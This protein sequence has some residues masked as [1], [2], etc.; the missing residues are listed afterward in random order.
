MGYG[1][2]NNV[3]IR[4][5][6]KKG[7]GPFIWILNNDTVVDK[8][9]L[10][11]LISCVKEDKSIGM[12]GSKLLYYEE[13]NILQAAG[14]GKISPWLGN[15]KLTACNQDDNGTWDRSFE[16]DYIC[17][18]S[19][20]IKKTVL[21]DIGLMDEQYFL[22]WEDADWGTEAKKKHYRLIYCPESKVWHKE[23]STSGGVT[24]LTDYYWVRN[25][26]LFTRKFYPLLLPIIP[27][28][29][30]I[31]YTI[32]RMLKKQPLNFYSFLSGTRDFLQ[33]KKG[34]QINLKRI[35]NKNN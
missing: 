19:L 34:K 33:G 18:A 32:V 16:L 29:Y 12:I 2:G 4:Y 9:A 27:F 3:G 17:G 6:L 11:K 14:G 24:K 30:F 10:L 26:L 28:S 15:T 1:A 31:K 35:R 8:N 5:L 20:L 22:Y 13:P 7:D 21:E 25:G 23:G